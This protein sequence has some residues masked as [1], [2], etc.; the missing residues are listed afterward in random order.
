MGDTL[1]G[2]LGAFNC[3]NQCIGGLINDF[4]GGGGVTDISSITSI[5][6][7]SRKFCC[8]PRGNFPEAQLSVM[9]ENSKN[10]S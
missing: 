4:F 10:V 8:C 3:S 1:Q 7:R 2:S 5:G 6:F 9:G